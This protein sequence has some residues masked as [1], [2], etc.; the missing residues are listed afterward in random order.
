VKK[1]SFTGFVEFFA[2][3]RKKCTNNDLLLASIP[4]I[5]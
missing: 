3:S 1:L 4:S 2:R 5:F